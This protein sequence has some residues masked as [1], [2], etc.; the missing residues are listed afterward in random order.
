MH[1]KLGASLRTGHGAGRAPSQVRL[2]FY[3]LP[4]TDRVTRIKFTSFFR[5]TLLLLN[6]KALHALHLSS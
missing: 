1:T 2:I 3:C 4:A 6:A 5:L